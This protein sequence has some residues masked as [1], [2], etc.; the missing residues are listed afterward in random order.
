MAI[1]AAIHDA[2]GAIAT[3]SEVF[4]MRHHNESASSIPCKIEEQGHDD[5]SIF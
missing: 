1:E 4:I 2:H 5:L 3:L